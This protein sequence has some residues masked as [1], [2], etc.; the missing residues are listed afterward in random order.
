MRY[1]RRIV[2]FAMF[3]LALGCAEQKTP[4][5]PAVKV[6][7]TLPERDATG[8]P[9]LFWIDIVGNEGT[10]MYR[11]RDRL[12]SEEDLRPLI[13]RLVAIDAKHP[14]VIDRLEGVEKP[15]LDHLA[16]ILKEAG[17]ENI[18]RRGKDNQ[19]VPLK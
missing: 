9:Q 14:I 1:A 15:E 3:V 11:V 4:P 6:D 17:A 2:V 19:A 5:P 18:S 13:K 10:V 7:M 16:T 12:V 8:G